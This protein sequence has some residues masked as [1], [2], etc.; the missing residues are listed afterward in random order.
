[1]GLST[2]RRLAALGILLTLALAACG[3]GGSQEKTAVAAANRA[4]RWRAAGVD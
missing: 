4:L 1:M 2:T 3:G